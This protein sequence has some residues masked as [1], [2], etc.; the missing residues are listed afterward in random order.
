MADEP[1]YLLHVI[2]RTC[3]AEI[4]S[5]EPDL[6]LRQLAVLLVVCLTDK[7]QT[8]RGLAA[9]LNVNKP[10]ITRAL[11]R[12]EELELA[13]RTADRR[14]RRSVVV[15]CTVGGAA[16]VERLGVEMIGPHRVVRREC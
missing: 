6:N 5:D 11:D 1:D 14:D 8:V 7:P 3:V 16:M 2:R 10:A 9:H 4:R 13:V 12:L 15:Q